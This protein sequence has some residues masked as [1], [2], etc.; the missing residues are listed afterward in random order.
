MISS[1]FNSLSKKAHVACAVAVLCACFVLSGCSGLSSSRILTYDFD[2][3]RA[4]AFEDVFTAS[5]VKMKGKIIFSTDEGK[6]KLNFILYRSGQ[7]VRFTGYRAMAGR[8][9]D[10]LFKGNRFWSVWKLDDV[11]RAEGNIYDSLVLIPGAS[12]RIG[13][14]VFY[15]IFAPFSHLDSYSKPIKGHGYTQYEILPAGQG[16]IKR[17]RENSLRFVSEQMFANTKHT[18]SMFYSDYTQ[19]MPAWPSTIR[20]IDSTGKVFADISI[21]SVSFG[22]GVLKK[23]IFN[24]V[25]F[26]EE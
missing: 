18:M 4:E 15:D 19:N 20:V 7:D 17:V 1:L 14:F 22:R 8:I 2:S 23:N 26:R 9:I 12:Q 3:D 10:I 24:E 5:D 11:Q 6:Q 16:W 13:V 25:L 21:S